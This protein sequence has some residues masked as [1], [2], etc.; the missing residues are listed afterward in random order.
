MMGFS[1]IRYRL[2]QGR[3]LVLDSDTG[4][5]LRA[6]GVS[7]DT[8]GAVGSLLRSSEADVVA[9][10]RAEV[11]SRVDVLSA[12]TAD[13]TPRALS[14][15][16]M[17]HR[18][19]LLTGRAV[20]LAFE[21]AQ[22]A[23]KPVAVAGILGSDMVSPTGADRLE[24]ELSEHAE[25]IAT[26]GAELLITRGQGSRFGLLAAVTAAGRTGLP[27]FAVLQGLGEGDGSTEGLYLELW[28][29]LATV[30]VSAVLF[31]VSRVEQA[32][33]SIQ[34][35]SQFEVD[36]KPVLGVLL[37]GSPGSLLGFP[38][39]DLDPNSWVKPAAELG[40][41]GARVIG[42]GAGTTEAHTEALAIALGEL[43]PSVPVARADKSS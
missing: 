8:P 35:A 11:R 38:D 19:A 27:I 17:Q 24:A 4:A 16:G 42:G 33:A 2:S 30:G 14:E 9:H 20:E 3:P 29:R 18:S 34:R 15:V 23:A 26:A 32:L 5:A 39:E 1:E 13:T 6:R 21:V 37:A 41:C 12:L 40:T 31:E 22:E 28:D 10:Y 25:R 7:L 43:H 36:P